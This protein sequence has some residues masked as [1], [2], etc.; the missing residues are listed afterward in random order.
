MWTGVDWDGEPNCSVSGGLALVLGILHWRCLEDT[1]LGSCWGV[2]AGEPK[3]MAFSSSRGCQTSAPSLEID[4]KS[5]SVSF[6]PC[7]VCAWMVACGMDPCQFLG[8]S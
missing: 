4:L 7:F 5:S 2:G 3:V 1:D 8:G 6:P